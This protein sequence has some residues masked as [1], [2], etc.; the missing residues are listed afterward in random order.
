MRGENKRTTTLVGAQPHEHVTETVPREIEA[1]L[2]A[3]HFDLRAHARFVERRG[4]TLHEA[5]GEAAESLWFHKG[6]RMFNAP[7]GAFNAE[8]THGTNRFR[9]RPI[10]R[11]PSPLISA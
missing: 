9:A 10:Q 11:L 7:G 8:L 1:M 3:N 2:R 4:G 5:P 6:A